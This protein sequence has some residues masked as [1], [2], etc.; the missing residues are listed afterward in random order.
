MSDSKGT[1]VS[2]VV[3]TYNRAR[4][5]AAA[6]D[7]AARQTLPPAEII[8]VDDGSSEDIAQICAMVGAPV[9]YVRQSNAGV[10]AARNRGI[11]ESSAEWVAFLD[12][13]DVWRPDKLEVQ[14]S[15]LRQHPQAGWSLSGCHVI[16]MNGALVDERGFERVFTVFRDLELSPAELLGRWL[17]PCSVTAGIAEHRLY[18]GDLFPL[19]FH[20]NVALPSSAAVRRALLQDTGGFDPE[21]RVA[22]ETEFFH[23]LA[24][25]APAVI[26][27]APLVGYRLT[28]SGSLTDPANTPTL[29]RNALLSVDRAA[30]RRQPLS[31]RELDAHNSG[32]RRLLLRLAYAELSM[33]NREGARQAALAA[34]RS[35]AAGPGPWCCSW[36]RSCR[37]HCCGSYTS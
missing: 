6:L 25:V 22:E 13:D 14:L 27:D 7:S 12:S 4:L 2:V 26:V 28:G 20:G 3:P 32:R 31:S 36:R 1:T 19:L 18:S 37:G 5:L 10:S 30:E 11:E 33:L 21:F 23:R 15:A 8:V 17:Q 34:V 16:D 24:A 9:R 35:G 29:V